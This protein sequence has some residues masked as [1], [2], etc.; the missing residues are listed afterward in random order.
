MYRIQVSKH[1]LPFTLHTHSMYNG[2]LQ[3]LFFEI[4]SYAN[5]TFVAF[6][7][8]HQSNHSHSYVPRGSD[9]DSLPIADPTFK[10]AHINIYTCV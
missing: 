8:S 10:H 7:S 6:F 9:A 4:F 2:I 1:A 5:I 3:F